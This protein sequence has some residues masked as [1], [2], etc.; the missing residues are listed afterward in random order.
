MATVIITKLKHAISVQQARL[1]L[2]VSPNVFYALMAAQTAH[3]V[4]IPHQT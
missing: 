2:V 1:H 3:Q 4:I